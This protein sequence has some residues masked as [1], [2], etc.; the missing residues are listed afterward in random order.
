MNTRLVSTT[1]CRVFLQ[2]LRNLCHLDIWMCLNRDLAQVACLKSP[3]LF[4]VAIQDSGELL[5]RFLLLSEIKPPFSV[6]VIGMYRGC[7]K[8]LQCPRNPRLV[9]SHSN[10]GL[11][12]VAQ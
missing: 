11:A 12:K 8:F 5:A 9:S 1:G 2:H 7:R 3:L 10:H 6:A 4:V